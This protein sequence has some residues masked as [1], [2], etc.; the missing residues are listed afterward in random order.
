[1]HGDKLLYL[2]NEKK[3]A[4][5]IISFWNVSKKSIRSIGLT[6][7]KKNTLIRLRI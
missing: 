2:N 7:K 1:M 3:I 4:N 5:L 6:K